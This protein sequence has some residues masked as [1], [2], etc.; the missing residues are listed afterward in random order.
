MMTTEG[1]I[2]TFALS[3]DGYAYCVSSESC[4]ELANATKDKYLHTGTLPEALDELRACFF[5]D[6]IRADV[7]TKDRADS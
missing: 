6:A 3:F 7:A 1:E 2:D 4:G 5:F